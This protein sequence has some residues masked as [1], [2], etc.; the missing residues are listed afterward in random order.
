MIIIY[1][2]DVVYDSNINRYN[3]CSNIKGRKQTKQTE[4]QNKYTR[5]QNTYIMYLKPFL[6]KHFSI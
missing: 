5:G 4:N 6:P 3:L 2:I 1:N